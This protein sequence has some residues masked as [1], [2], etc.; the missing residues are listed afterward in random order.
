MDKQKSVLT[1]ELSNIEL[2]MDILKARKESIL[3]RLRLIEITR[4]TII[5][6][7]DTLLHIQNLDNLE[8]QDWGEEQENI[9]NDIIQEMVSNES[10]K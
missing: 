4:A 9:E 7:P 2:G 8:E 10:N 3:A 6:N 1:K 5:Q